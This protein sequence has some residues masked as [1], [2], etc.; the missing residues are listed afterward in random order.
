MP[1]VIRALAI[2]VLEY[3]RFYFSIMRSIN[4]LSAATVE[5]AAQATELRAQFHWLAPTFWPQGLQIKASHGVSLRK[6]TG[7]YKFPVL[8]VFDIRGDSQERVHRV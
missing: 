4:I 2:R 8:R 6:S 1:L 7:I 3:P 5:A